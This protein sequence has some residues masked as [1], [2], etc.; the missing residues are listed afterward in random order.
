MIDRWVRGQPRTTAEEVIVPLLL[1]PENDERPQLDW[2]VAPLRL[3]VAVCAC[4]LHTQEGKTGRLEVT[5]PAA[6]TT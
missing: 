6:W 2:P 4:D 5:P 1:R 3:G